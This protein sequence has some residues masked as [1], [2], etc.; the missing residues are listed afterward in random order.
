M[1]EGATGGALVRALWETIERRDWD[2]VAALLD[3]EFVLE[4]PQSGEVIRGPAD[5][6]AVNAAYPGEWHITV[7]RVMDWGSS[8]L[9]EVRVDFPDR[10]DHAVSLF[11]MRDGRIASIREWWP[12]PFPAAEWRRQ[13]VEQPS[14]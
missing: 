10:A 11:T 1:A 8:A 9:S 3:D 2:G 14:S 6:V 5:F 13:W 7:E 12:D 4:W